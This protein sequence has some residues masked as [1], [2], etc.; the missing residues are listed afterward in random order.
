MQASYSSPVMPVG[1]TPSES[2]DAATSQ[3]T[4]TVDAVLAGRSYYQ[5]VTGAYHL[6][7]TSA[8]DARYISNVPDFTGTGKWPHDHGCF[9]GLGGCLD[10]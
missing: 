1:D 9:Y 8:D 7:V 5:V 6:S 3:H 10:W 4:S 2:W